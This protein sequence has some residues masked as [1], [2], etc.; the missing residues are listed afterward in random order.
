MP[1]AKKFV[2]TR[3]HNRRPKSSNLNNAIS[4]CAKLR[5]DAGLTQ[6][7]LSVSAGVNLQALQK[8]EKGYIQKMQLET[9]IRVA[10][11]LDVA[12]SELIPALSYK[13][14]R[15][16]KVQKPKPIRTHEIRESKRNDYE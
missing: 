14:R 5:L 6:T 4:R 12:P 8:I 10:L 13:P 2:K 16:T 7:E 11:A 9:L 3:P 15:V 1:A